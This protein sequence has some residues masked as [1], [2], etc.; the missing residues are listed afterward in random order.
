MKEKK[1]VT[2]EV[3]AK[4]QEFFEMLQ[5]SGCNAIVIISG[6][7]PENRNQT[8]TLTGIGGNPLELAKSIL[9]AAEDDERITRI[10][11]AT[12]LSMIETKI[13]ANNDNSE[14]TE[15]EKSAE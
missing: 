2:A 1:V 14:G 15:N 13:F 6:D 10:F 9:T 11:T 5:E 8:K 7:N 12:A 3:E 4:T